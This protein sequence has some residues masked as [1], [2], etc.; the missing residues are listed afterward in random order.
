M[1]YLKKIGKILLITFISIIVL[2]LILNT[3]YYFN[4]ISNNIYTRVLQ[5]RLLRK[6]NLPRFY[7]GFLM[8]SFLHFCLV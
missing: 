7:L 1:N 3:L 5:Y 2:G 6:C 4:F 8:S